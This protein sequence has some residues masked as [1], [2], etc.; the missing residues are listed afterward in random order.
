[1]NRLQGCPAPCPQQMRKYD[2]L[3][4]C[5]K[6]FQGWRRENTCGNGEIKGW[7]EGRSRR[8]KW[9]R[10]GLIVH[11]Y[12][13][14]HSIRTATSNEIFLY[15]IKYFYIDFTMF[16]MKDVCVCVTQM[17]LTCPV[18]TGEADTP[19]CEH[20][21]GGKAA[22]TQQ[23]GVSGVPPTRPKLCLLQYEESWHQLKI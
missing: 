22:F 23:A 19:A 15:F 18:G 10:A 14:L 6:G 13:E 12:W 9:P 8:P 7:A 2:I 11:T 4:Q 3:L 17:C 16:Y 5:L 21:H 1:M 20:C